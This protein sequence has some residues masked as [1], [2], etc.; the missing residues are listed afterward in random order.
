MAGKF[1]VVL[2][3]ECEEPLRRLAWA[4]GYTWGDEPNVKALVQAIAKGQ[5]TIGNAV[6]FSSAQQ[7]ALAWAAIAAYEGGA[8]EE[9]SVFGNL[10]KS[11]S[12]IDQPIADS[13]AAKLEPLQKQWV[14]EVFA[15]I[16]QQKS[17]KIAYQ[18][19]AGRPFQFSV[20]GAQFVVHERRTYLD[21]WAEET[22]ANQDIKELHH[23]WCLRLDRIVDAEI[24]PL[25]KKWRLL[26]VVEVEIQL[27]GG[28][29]HAYEPR[30]ED[31]LIEWIEGDI[32]RV[33]RSITSTFWLMRE[34]LRYGKDCKVL[35]PPELAARV[36]RQFAEAAKLY[37]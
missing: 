11:L 24:I 5:Q 20:C 31:T 26:D 3:K 32:K 22:E 12:G 14:R 34:I 25:K 29:A 9:A 27:F 23:N 33:N 17:F 15:S 36:G 18:D 35:S 7:R 4:L 6:V 21:C 16:D 37:E 10:F 2:D 13:V 30:L 1:S 28:L 8:W 19:A